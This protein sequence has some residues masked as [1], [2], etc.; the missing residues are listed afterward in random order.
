MLIIA[1]GISSMW[2]VTPTAVV[3]AEDTSIVGLTVEPTWLFNTFSDA[4]SAVR[5]TAVVS[6]RASPVAGSF[7]VG[8][9][10][11]HLSAVVSR[12]STFSDSYP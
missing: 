7:A 9:R 3:S 12:T 10:I 1:T 5:A 8:S 6:A 2:E 4:I 11:G